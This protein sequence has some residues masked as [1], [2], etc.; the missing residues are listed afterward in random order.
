[1]F[2]TQIVLLNDIDSVAGDAQ[3][4]ILSARHKLNIRKR[5]GE[6]FLAK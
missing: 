2:E 6:I 5:E 3:S 4:N 1:M